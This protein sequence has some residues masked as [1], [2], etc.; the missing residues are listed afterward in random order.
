VERL[1][2]ASNIDEPHLLAF[3]RVRIVPDALRRTGTTRYLNRSI[4]YQH[5]MEI[6][7]IS[8]R[9]ISVLALSASLGAA[10]A[11]DTQQPVPESAAVV[12]K[13]CKASTGEVREECERVAEQMKK[14]SVPDRVADDRKM[15]THSSPIMD[16]KK[17]QVTEKSEQEHK[18]K[19]PAKAISR[20]NDGKQDER[21][22]KPATTSPAQ[23]QQ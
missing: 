7:S 5:R 17:Q 1:S 23:P 16:T 8:L 6:M 11:A 14:P 20:G 12:A 4:R 19:V 15:V 10:Y 18:A 13:Q 22:I 21:S 2:I 3:G 9:I